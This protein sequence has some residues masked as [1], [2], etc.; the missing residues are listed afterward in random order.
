MMRAIAN[1]MPPIT[2]SGQPVSSSGISSRWW[3]AG[4]DTL[5]ISSEHTVMPS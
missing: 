3:M 2:S 1:A 5:R 4:S